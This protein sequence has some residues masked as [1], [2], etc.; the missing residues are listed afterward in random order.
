MAIDRE[1]KYQQMVLRGKYQRL[2]TYLRSLQ[3]QEWRTSFNEVEQSSDSSCL[4]PHGCTGPGGEIR[5]AA[6]ATATPLPGASPAGRRR[7]SIWMA[8][9]CCSG[10]RTRSPYPGFPSTRRGPSTPPRCG[11]K[12]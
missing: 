12:V 1:S 4:R 5:E 7:R 6:M 2:Y 8:R 3:V 11:R 10:E 9:C